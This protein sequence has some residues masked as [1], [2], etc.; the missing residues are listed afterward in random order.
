MDVGSI[1]QS[2]AVASKRPARTVDLAQQAYKATQYLEARVEPAS[3]IKSVTD[4]RLELVARGAD[5]EVIFGMGIS[6]KAIDRGASAL[7]REAA[8]QAR[9]RA[10]Q[11]YAS[12]SNAF[13]D[14]LQRSIDKKIAKTISCLLYTSDAADD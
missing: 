13:A 9:K 3:K 12:A 7:A 14:A 4:R 10:E 6:Q 5:P 2:S 11:G 8:A 1:V